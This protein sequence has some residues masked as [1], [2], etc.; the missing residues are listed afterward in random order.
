M[1]CHAKPERRSMVEAAGVEP[2]S[3]NLP[4]KLLHAYPG[5]SSL[6][7]RESPRAGLPSSQP[8]WFDPLPIGTC[9]GRFR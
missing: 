3:G 7:F 4:L 9:S 5:F 2:A 8:T 1:A 6:A